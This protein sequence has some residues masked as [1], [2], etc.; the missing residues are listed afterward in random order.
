[1]ARDPKDDSAELPL[2]WG[3]ERRMRF[4]ERRL[5]WSGAINRTDIMNRFGIAPN[6]ASTDMTRVRE[7]HPGCLLYDTVGTRPTGLPIQSGRAAPGSRGSSR[8]ID[9][10][11]APG[12]APAS[13]ELS[14]RAAAPVSDFDQ[15]IHHDPR[16]EP[17][18]LTHVNQLDR[19]QAPL[20]SLIIGYERLWPLQ[21]ACN[22]LL[23]EPGG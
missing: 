23:L 1:M 3:V 17:N 9:S 21:T 11:L 10:V 7:A 12:A 22:I 18:H 19:V 14:L 15:L 4:A 6:Q 13:R 16:I 5:D 20:A 8:S 2:R